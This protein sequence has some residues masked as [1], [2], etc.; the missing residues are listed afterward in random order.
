MEEKLFWSGDCQH[1]VL[2][3]SFDSSDGRRRSIRNML[4]TFLAQII[5]HHMPAYD[6][7]LIETRFRLLDES[8]GGWT[9]HDLINFFEFFR[10]DGPLINVSCVINN[11]DGCTEDSQ[12]AFLKYF[13]RYSIGFD[14]EWKVA[15]TSREPLVLADDLKK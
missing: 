2:Y 11:F 7:S 10:R 1:L 4:A 9:N 14:T 6:D 5:C 13:S 8:R 12:K 15:F 3:F